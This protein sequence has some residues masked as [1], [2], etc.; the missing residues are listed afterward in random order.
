MASLPTLLAPHLEQLGKTTRPPSH[1]V[2][3]IVSC[4]GSLTGNL[5]GRSNDA[6]VHET[7][8]LGSCSMR[9]RYG[10]SRKTA[11]MPIRS[12]GRVPEH[13]PVATSLKCSQ[14]FSSSSTTKAAV[15]SS[16]KAARAGFWNG[17]DDDLPDGFDAT[18]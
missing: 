10:T 7:G 6:E 8:R 12:P 1:L 18:L 16:Q 2:S 9:K 4:L 14:T 17:A 13:E 11:T 5:P 15:T 3:P